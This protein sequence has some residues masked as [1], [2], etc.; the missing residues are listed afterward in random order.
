[1]DE[2][3]NLFAEICQSSWF[4]DTSMILF[5]NKRDLFQKKIRTFPIGVPPSDDY[6]GRFMDYTGI[7]GRQLC[8]CGHGY[9]I[10]DERCTCGAYDSGVDYI[11][12]KFLCRAK[13]SQQIYVHETCAT[14]TSNIRHVFD[15]CMDI[16]LRKNFETSGFV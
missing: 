15:S 16:I 14:D 2:A 9:P 8:V 12:R 6:A 1:M 7:S 4:E 11:R 5:L 10:D 3:I 13:D